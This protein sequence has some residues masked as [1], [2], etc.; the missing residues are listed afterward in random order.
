MRKIIILMYASMIFH[1]KHSHCDSWQRQRQT[2]RNLY[3]LLK[4]YLIASVIKRTIHTYFVNNS[5][6]P[7]NTTNSLKNFNRIDIYSIIY[8]KTRETCGVKL[9]INNRWLQPK[10]FS[11]IEEF[12]SCFFI[13]AFFY[14]PFFCKTSFWR[15]QN[16]IYVRIYVYICECVC[17]RSKENQTLEFNKNFLIRPE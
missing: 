2:G 7:I 16:I 3:F 12:F 6:R 5:N 10:H 13:I 14:F 9:G 1:G 4:Y 11:D 17:D 8:N 15:G